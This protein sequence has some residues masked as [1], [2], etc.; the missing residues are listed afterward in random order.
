MALLTTPLLSFTAR[1]KLAKTLVYSAW[2]G[3]ATAR[4]YVVPANPNS[5]DQQTQRNAMTGVVS[6]YRNYMA[7]EGATAWNLAA[8]V[9]SSAMSGFNAFCSNAVKRVV[10]DADASFAVSCTTFGGNNAEFTMKN[11]DD[12][13]TG[14][15]AGNFTLMRGTD[16]KGLLS[17]GTAA[18]AGGKVTIAAGSGGDVVYVQLRKDSVNR[19]GIT[20]LTLT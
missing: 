2:K 18:I 12:G 5:A 7:A 1:G 11:L 14:D 6:F 8:S 17:Y 15:E 16:P 19:S 20:K 10:L 3:L 13:G 9:L 4:Q